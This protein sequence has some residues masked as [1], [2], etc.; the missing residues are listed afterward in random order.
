VLGLIATRKVSNRVA[1]LGRVSYVASRPPR[2]GTERSGDVLSNALVGAT[3][4]KSRPSG[5]RVGFFG[6]AALPLGGGGGDS[7]QAGAAAAL[8]RAIATRSA[9]DN[10]LFATNFFTVIGGVT[11]ARVTRAATI[12]AEATVLQLFRARGPKSQDGARTNFTSGLH[13]GHSFSIRVSGG[14]ELRYQRWLSEAAPVRSNPAA[15]ETLTLA[16]GPRLH[17]RLPGNR[18]IRPGLSLTVPLDDPLGDQKYR[19]LQIDVPVS[20]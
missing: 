7:P 3:F 2:P 9:M 12:Q 10:A 5:V 8:A 18:W 19:T 1:L 11:V 16:F 13:V 14:A 15:R 17:V 20:F 4:L 6:A